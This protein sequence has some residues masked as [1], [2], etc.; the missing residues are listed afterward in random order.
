M[1]TIIEKLIR[2]AERQEIKE[3]SKLKVKAKIKFRRSKI[4]GRV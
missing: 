2:E 3:E 4:V 1:D